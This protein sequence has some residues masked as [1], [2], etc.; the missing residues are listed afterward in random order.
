MVGV[1]DVSGVLDNSGGYHGDSGEG[2]DDNVD[3]GGDDVGGDECG[4]KMM[5]MTIA[6]IFQ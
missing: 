4:N 6:F 5:E 1:G 3:G 2:Y